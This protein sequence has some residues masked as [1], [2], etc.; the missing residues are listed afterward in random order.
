MLLHY[1][2]IWYHQYMYQFS[3]SVYVKHK[4]DAT[5]EVVQRKTGFQQ[6]TMIFFAEIE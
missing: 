6:N 5:E 1:P 4:G 2:V 3:Q